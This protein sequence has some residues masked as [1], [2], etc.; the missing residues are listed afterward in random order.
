MTRYVVGLPLVPRLGA[1]LLVRKNRPAWQAGRLNGPGG[2]VERA[3]DLYETDPAAMS[4]EFLEEVGVLV[5]AERWAPRVTLS[6][7]GW[8]CCFLVARL[9]DEEA[10]AAMEGRSGRDEPAEMAFVDVLP[11]DLV[12]NLRW[13][14][15]LALDDTVRPVV[16]R[17]RSA[18]GEGTRE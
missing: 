10:A 12:P 1:V 2:K 4:R 15:P 18:D 16:V 14:I 9:T 7:D 3:G 13:I 17:D 8:R 5:R 6:G 11:R